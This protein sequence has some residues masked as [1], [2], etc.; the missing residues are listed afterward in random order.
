[1][2]FYEIRQKLKALFEICS[3]S[4]LEPSSENFPNVVLR[5]LIM[6]RGLFFSVWDCPLCL[7]SSKSLRREGWNLFPAASQKGKSELHKTVLFLHR[8]LG[9]IFWTGPIFRTMDQLQGQSYKIQLATTTFFSFPDLQRDL[10]LSS[11]SV[12]VCGE[13][14]IIRAT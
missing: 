8:T 12:C 4:K 7:D 2:L 5:Q 9:T 10:F 1:M 14:E 13:G 3:F 11:F 6:P